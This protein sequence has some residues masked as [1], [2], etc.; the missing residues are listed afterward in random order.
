MKKFIVLSCF[1]LLSGCSVLDKYCKDSLITERQITLDRTYYES[2]QELTKISE[3]ANFFDILANDKAVFDAYSRC[4]RKQDASIDMLKQF[5]GYK[6][7]NNGS[8]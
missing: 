2:C 6:E 7:L 5:T 8:R 1:I 3:T 4:K